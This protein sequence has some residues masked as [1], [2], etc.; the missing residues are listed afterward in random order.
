MNG[1]TI[2]CL[3]NN[4]FFDPTSKHHVMRELAKS[5]HVLWINWHASRRPALN[6]GDFSSI[7]EK[8]KQFKNGLANVQERLWVVTPVVLP[9]PSWE[10][11]R[12]LDR[13]LLKGQPGPV[14]RQ[15]RG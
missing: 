9:L 7:A 11:A 1:K 3:A 12:R 5:N 10:L 6:R 4:Y 2:I 15:L 14:Q 8:L 13:W